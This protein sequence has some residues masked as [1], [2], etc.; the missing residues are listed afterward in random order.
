MAALSDYLEA[1]LLNH[2]FRTSTL[3]KLPHVAIALTSSPPVDSNTG[4][5]INEIPLTASI[6][7]S[8]VSTNYS[9]VSLGVPVSSGDAQWEAVG[10][11][12][13]TPY[14][15]Y[16][17]KFG[18]TSGNFYPLYLSQSQASSAAGGGSPNTQTFSFTDFPGVT[19]Y[20]PS[21]VNQMVQ[22]GVVSKSI[23]TEYEGNGFIKNKEQLVFKRALSEWGWVSG[24]AIVD[25]PNHK[26]GNLLMHSRLVNP[27]YVYVG[28]TIRFDPNSLE[29][30][31]K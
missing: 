24:I 2:V 13:T 27:R 28:D 16:G 21:G 12:M 26:S 22:S 17:N 19:F 11:D 1:A 29:I 9:R 23:Y 15:V 8:N 20:G 18:N 4:S 7:G 10:V 3:A 31:L 25:D 14:N 6:G 5:T 30:S